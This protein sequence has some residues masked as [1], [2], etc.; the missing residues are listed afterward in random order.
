V[1]DKKIVKLC[2]RVQTM[3]FSSNWNS[4]FTS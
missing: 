3:R 1:N 2:A 4:S